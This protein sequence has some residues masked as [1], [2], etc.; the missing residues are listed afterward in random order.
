MGILTSVCFFKEFTFT[1]TIPFTFS[2]IMKVLV[3]V[4]HLS[5]TGF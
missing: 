4:G 5:R 1:F 2:E 3:F